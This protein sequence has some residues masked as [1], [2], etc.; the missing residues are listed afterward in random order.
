[1][2]FDF[3]KLFYLPYFKVEHVIINCHPS[4]TNE[5]RHTYL[6]FLVKCVYEKDV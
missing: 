3:G 5:E 6:D 1:M 2:G 4:V